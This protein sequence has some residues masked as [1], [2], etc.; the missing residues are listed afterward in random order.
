VD[1]VVRA[2]TSSEEAKNAA[3]QA[4]PALASLAVELDPDTYGGAVLVGVNGV[5]VIS[6]GSSGERAILNAVKVA[7]DAVSDKLVD[8]IQAVIGSGARFDPWP[9]TPSR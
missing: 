3:T 6:H 4:M 9:Q 1:A 2:L 7:H 5:C 8:R